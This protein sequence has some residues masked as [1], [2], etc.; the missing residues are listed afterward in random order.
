LWFK[1]SGQVPD[2]FCLDYGELFLIL[3]FAKKIFLEQVIATSMYLS[4]FSIGRGH[5][6]YC[7][8]LSRIS[9]VR[10]NSS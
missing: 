7:H 1:K 3:L 5:V 6:R 9:A 2:F 4:R 8:Y 10:K